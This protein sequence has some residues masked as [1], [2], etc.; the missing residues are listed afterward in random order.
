MFVCLGIC[1]KLTLQA[2]VLEI[3]YVKVEWLAEPLYIHRQTCY[4]F[5]RERRVADVPTD[6]PSCSKQHAVIQY[7]YSVLLYVVL[8]Y[9]PFYAYLNSVVLWIFDFI[10]YV[11]SPRACY[12]Q[13][14]C[15]M[16]LLSNNVRVSLGFVMT[17]L[18]S[19]TL[20]FP[21]VVAFAAR[22]FYD[23]LSINHLRTVNCVLAR[24]WLL[25]L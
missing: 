1:F 10:L 16:L 11:P 20:R 9:L 24:N 13:A 12:L 25:I 19:K 6:H 22:H 8:C 5:G 15:V 21:S 23:L 18:F 7:R 14:T 17:S 3:L 4:L 2:L